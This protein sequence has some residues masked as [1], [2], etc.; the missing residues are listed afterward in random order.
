MRL[1]PVARAAGDGRTVGGNE[2]PALQF[3]P[4]DVFCLVLQQHRDETVTAGEID[5]G[6]GKAPSFIEGG[7]LLR[8][9]RNQNDIESAVIVLHTAGQLRQRPVLGAGGQGAKQQQQRE[10]ETW[11]ARHHGICCMD[12]LRGS[13][14]TISPGR[15]QGAL[16]VLRCCAVG[17]AQVCHGSVEI[18]GVFCNN[19]ILVF[20]HPRLNP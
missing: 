6:I 8:R 17:A 10:H 16:Q 5:H 2:T 20:H 19:P 14:Y 1:P 13:G 11:A 15:G 7:H 9:A 12:C 3:M 4:Q 18:G